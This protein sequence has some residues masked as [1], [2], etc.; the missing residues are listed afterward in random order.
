[1][2]SAARL[3][4]GPH[5][6]RTMADDT[7][8]GDHDE[9]TID[10]L[11]ELVAG[12]DGV[13]RAHALVSVGGHL[14]GELDLDE[15]LAAVGAA[16]DL[17]EAADDHA[18]VGM[19]DHNAAVV[20]GDGLGDGLDAVEL[21]ESAADHYRRA[22]YD[23]Q[24]ADCLLHA[25][26]LLGREP[27]LTDDALD[28][29]GQAVAAYDEAGLVSQAAFA[30]ALLARFVA[31]SGCSPVEPF[32]D[33]LWARRAAVL[34]D[35]RGVAML[36]EALAH[37]L[38]AAGRPDEGL[39]RLDRADAIR[40]AFGDD[41][42]CSDCQLLRARLL[43]EAGRFGDAVRHARGLRKRF[44]RAGNG[45]AAAQCDLWAGRALAGLGRDDEAAQALLAASVVLEATGDES[46]AAEAGHEAAAIRFSASRSA[47]ELSP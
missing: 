26:E 12:S 31:R 6:S 44:R 33:G 10:E 2:T 9:P 28:R 24:A 35:G 47:A 8:D 39:T 37:C 5:T 32:V 13:E 25:A 7:C 14:L 17:F 27:G 1:M 18:G 40:D 19:C 22:G 42:V 20:V 38:G 11:W 15:A 41:H 3:S 23:E 43:V 46:G 36:E 30:Y 45:A 4:R 34:G 21:H 29:F 16:R